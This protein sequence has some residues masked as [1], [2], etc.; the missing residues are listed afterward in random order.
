M[1]R[2]T[3]A[4]TDVIVGVD[5]HK[6]QHAAFAID[7]LGIALGEPITIA[8]TDQG[9]AEL[10]SW[11]EEL[12]RAVAFGVEGCGSYGIGLARFLRRHEFHVEEVARPV[13]RG[14]RRL[15]GKSDAIDAEHAARTVLAGTGTATPKL[16]NGIVE[17]IRLIK[18]ARDIAVK[19]RTSTMITF[20]AVLVTA[21]SDLREQLKPLTKHKL[22]LACAKLERSGPLSDPLV[23]MRYALASLARR[24][25]MLHDEIKA[26]TAHLK[27]L[28]HEAAPSLVSTFGVGY[29]SAA[30]LLI[31]AGDNAER[32]RSESAFAKMCGACPIPAG[33]ARTKGRHRL[34]RGGNRQANSSLYRSLS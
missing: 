18:I 1:H 25:L 7:G 15:C 10:V 11:A 28:T 20:K 34:N 6:D 12:G 30:E 4:P 14:A 17:A 21:A 3:L 5:T 27:A 13:R 33:S 9:Y 16:A 32:I 19:A 8:A 23:A 26:H 22:L 29:D 24:W 31:A 2:N